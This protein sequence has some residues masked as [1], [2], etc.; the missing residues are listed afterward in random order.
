MKR[1]TG[2]LFAA[3]LSGL[4]WLVAHAQQPY[5]GTTVVTLKEPGKAT[6][7]AT[8]KISARVE[9]IDL[10]QRKVV[11]K[12]PHG[13]L[14][15]VDVPPEVSDLERLK[16]GDLV[17]VDYGEALTL[18]LKPAGKEL[19]SRREISGGTPVGAPARHVEITADVIAVDVSSQTVSLRGPQQTFELAVRDPE[20]LKLI[21][22]GDQVHAV[23]AEAAAVSIVA[24]R[25]KSQRRP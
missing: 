10:R 25:G 1:R 4:G 15:M 7:S 24:A 9:A 13:N 12:G 11:L 22:V 19:R 23:Y 16:V 8:V 2:V 14:T 20:Q 5:A 6:I 3:L 21:K 18:A 17:V